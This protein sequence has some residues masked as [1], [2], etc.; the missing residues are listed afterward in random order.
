MDS[1]FIGPSPCALAGLLFALGETTYD[2]VEYYWVPDLWYEQP[3]CSEPAAACAREGRVYT[4]SVP[5]EHELVHALRR[6]RLPAVFEEGLACVFGDIGWARTPASRERL[7]EILESSDPVD[8]SDYA[9]AGHFVAFLLER[10]G[11]GPLTRLGAIAN[12][13]DD[14][15]KVRD[16]FEEVYGISLDQALAEYESYP[17]CVDLAWKDRRIACSQAGIPRMVVSYTPRRSSTSN[18]NSAIFSSGSS[19]S[20][21]SKATSRPRW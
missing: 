8:F 17:D 19:W 16:S 2:R 10:D 20:A 14:S 6:N 5:D 15:S 11:L 21:T 18:R 7:L 1:A 12:Y 9:R 3:W 13:H 4:Q